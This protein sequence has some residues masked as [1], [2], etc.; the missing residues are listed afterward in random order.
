MMILV[1]TEI[2]AQT[3]TPCASSVVNRHNHA[4]GDELSG[5]SKNTKEIFFIH[6][7]LRMMNTHLLVLNLEPVW[8]V[9]LLLLLTPLLLLWKRFQQSTHTYR[10]NV[11][12]QLREETKSK[13]MQHCPSENNKTAS[14]SLLSTRPYAYKWIPSYECAAWQ[15]L[16]AIHSSAAQSWEVKTMWAESDK[17]LHFSTCACH[18]SRVPM[19][20]NVT[21]L[22]NNV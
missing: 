14:C 8:L 9:L 19:L 5:S 18:P 10:L 6:E 15:G 11:A 17:F 13:T 22:F 20:E 16:G 3:P 21:P 2:A 4:K 12:M 1:L 7:W